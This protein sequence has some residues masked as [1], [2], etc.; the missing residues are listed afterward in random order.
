MQYDGHLYALAQMLS[1]QKFCAQIVPGPQV[2]WQ[3]W[4]TAADKHESS[5]QKLTEPPSEQ[6]VPHEAQLFDACP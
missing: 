4:G 2:T 5:R 3:S 6:E 1:T